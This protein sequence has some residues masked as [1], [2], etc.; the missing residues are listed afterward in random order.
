MILRGFSTPGPPPV[1]TPLDVVKYIILECI[2]KLNIFI[3]IKVVKNKKLKIH[4][5]SFFVVIIFKVIC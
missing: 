1:N 5:N 2:L 4:F 3:V